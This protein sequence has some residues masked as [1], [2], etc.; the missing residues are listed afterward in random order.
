MAV[1]IPLLYGSGFD[2]AIV[3]GLILLPGCA[4]FG[5]ASV[6]AATINGRG[7]PGFSLRAGAISTPIA[8]VLYAVLIPLM[9][10]LGAAIASSLSYAINFVI[11]AV[12]YRRA[13]GERVAPLLVPTRE[14]VADLR[15][16]VRRSGAGPVV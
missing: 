2:E 1:A 12:Y 13:T 9:D 11:T 4:L 14:E 10:E 7:F 6:L 5:I 16:L 8:L 3:L 15:A